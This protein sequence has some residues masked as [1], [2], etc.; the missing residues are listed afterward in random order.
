MTAN[1][2]GP[3]KTVGAIGIMAS[4]VAALSRI[5]RMRLSAAAMTASHPASPAVGSA[6]ICSTRITARQG[7][8][9]QQDDAKTTASCGRGD[10]GETTWHDALSTKKLVRGP[11]T[12]MP[13]RTPG[14]LVVT[15]A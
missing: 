13:A 1:A 6:S 4:T 14:P 9:S 11:M 2:M 8:S 5:G 3:Q 15:R 12:A 10:Y 7:G